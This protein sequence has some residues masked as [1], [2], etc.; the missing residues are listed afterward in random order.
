MFEFVVINASSNGLWF[1]SF[2]VEGY[3]GHVI[4]AIEG[5]KKFDD[6]I[7]IDFAEVFPSADAVVV[8]YGECRGFFEVV[9]HCGAGVRN[10]LAVVG[11][12]DG[13]GGYGKWLS[14]VNKYLE[15][16]DEGVIDRGIEVVAIMECEGEDASAVGNHGIMENLC[17]NGT[18]C[19][20]IEVGEEKQE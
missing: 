8:T 1:N 17:A 15:A 16:V 19:C 13:N 18:S 20:V 11:F 3:N 12:V 4:F 7:D 2:F 5:F 10:A 14:L 9:V 6:D